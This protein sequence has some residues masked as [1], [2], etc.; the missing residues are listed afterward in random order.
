MSLAFTSL[1]RSK[2]I[3][4]AFC[5]AV[6][7]WTL[8]WTEDLFCGRIQVSV[9]YHTDMGRDGDAPVGV[10]LVDGLAFAL[11]DVGGEADRSSIARYLV[12]LPGWNI[13]RYLYFILLFFSLQQL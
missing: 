10:G 6:L 5:E 8:R 3:R 2:E 7:V 4:H 9:D 11:V 12:V 1:E 13:T